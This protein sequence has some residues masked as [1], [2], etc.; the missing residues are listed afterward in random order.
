MTTET[1]TRS[2]KGV[3]LDDLQTEVEK[4]LLLL[5]DRQTGL[6][7]WNGWMKERLENI[8]HLTGKALG[9]GESDVDR[10]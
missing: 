4:L 5:K 9:T 3:R 1:D 8:H 10:N 2:E 7:G 6:M